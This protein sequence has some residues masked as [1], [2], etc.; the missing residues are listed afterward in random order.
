[1]RKLKIAGIAVAVLAVALYASFQIFFRTAVPSYE[2]SVAIDG[3]GSKVEVRTDEHGIPHI[4]AENDL[5]LFFAQ[6][7]VTARERMF[8]MEITRLAGRGELSSLFGE[9]T[10]EKDKFLKT[11]GIHRIAKAGYRAMSAETRAI[12]DAYAAGVNAYIRDA[13]TLPREFAILG[14]Q[15]EDML[16]PEYVDLFATQ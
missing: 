15:P 16:G 10:I 2:G 14:A 12:I 6:G 5:D 13:K 1:M 8:Q 3:L 4:F 11:V 9:A 7:Y